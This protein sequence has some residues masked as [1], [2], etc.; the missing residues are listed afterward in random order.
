MEVKGAVASAQQI[1]SDREDARLALV[2]IAGV[3][4]TALVAA[5]TASNVPHDE[6]W[7][8]AVGRAICVAVPIAV[9]IYAWRRE[10]SRR[11]GQLLVA[12][13]FA[14]GLSTLAESSDELVYSTGRVAAW[15]TEV[16]VAY[17][18]LSF[19]TGRLTMRTDRPARLGHGGARG[20]AL[21]AD[22]PDSRELSRSGR[23]HELHGGLP[24]QRVL[25]PV[26]R[27]GVRRLGR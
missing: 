27:A 22:G 7:L 23:V 13:A 21:P 4:L 20:P 1:P 12:T 9:G 5:L 2:G 6:V 26:R 8:A 10:H 3:A 11:F 25:L 18:I 17:L 15:I 16:G 24:G 14:W 19:P